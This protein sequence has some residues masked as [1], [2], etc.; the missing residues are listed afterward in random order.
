MIYYIHS[1]NAPRDHLMPRF[2]EIGLVFSLIGDLF[3]MSNEISSFVVGTVF[4][5]IAHILYVFAFR[6]G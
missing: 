6:M 1:K 2:V 4:F 5:V 3:L